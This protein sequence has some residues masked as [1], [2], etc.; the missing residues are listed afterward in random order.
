MICRHPDCLG[1]YDFD[2]IAH[3][4]KQ[5]FVEGRSTVSLLAEAGSEREKEEIAL[6]SLLDVEDEQIRDL[7]LH[8]RYSSQCKVL[9]CRDRLRKLIEEEL[10][11]EW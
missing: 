3:Y 1:H 11:V 10:S 5:R 4:A 2:S 9:D 6:V 7:E 8:C